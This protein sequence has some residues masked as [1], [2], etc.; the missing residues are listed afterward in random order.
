M[1]QR[2]KAIV[3]SGIAYYD[4]WCQQMGLTAENRRSC[5]PVRYDH[6]DPRHPTYHRNKGDSDSGKPSSS[7]NKENPPC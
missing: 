6:D 4:K 1:W 2:I 5:A 7:C 3:S